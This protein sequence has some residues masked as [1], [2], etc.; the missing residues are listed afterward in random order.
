MAVEALR[1]AEV[2]GQQGIGVERLLAV[3]LLEDRVLHLADDEVE[4]L[5][6]EDLLLEVADPEP[7]PANLV[8]VGRADATPCCAEPVV[9]ANA[10]L[11]LVEE[12]VVAHHHVSAL[13]D[14]QVVGLDPPLSDLVDLLEQHPGVDDDPVADDA[15]AARVEDA[16]G[17]QLELELAVLGDDGVAGVVAALA[18]DGEVG[19]LGQEVDDLALALVPPLPADDDD[20]HQAMP[21]LR[22]AVGTGRVGSKR[23]NH[24]RR[25]AAS[26]ARPQAGSASPTTRRGETGRLPPGRPP[27]M[28][29]TTSLCLVRR[30]GRSARRRRRGPGAAGRGSRSASARAGSGG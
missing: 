5:A 12:R 27:T 13:A 10:L 22:R 19:T 4:L 26:L 16:A 3:Q 15:G 24:M 2:L 28:M 20:D 8:A 29:M 14:D 18:A 21:S 30:R 25:G 11:E 1:V 23:H 9:A 17:Q 7:D 6:Q